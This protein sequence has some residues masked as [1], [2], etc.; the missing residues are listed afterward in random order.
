M[1]TVIIKLFYQLM[2]DFIHFSFNILNL[3]VIENSVKSD[4]IIQLV[5]RIFEIPEMSCNTNL[6]CAWWR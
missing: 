4:D 6:R 5:L 3:Y 2:S 1:C